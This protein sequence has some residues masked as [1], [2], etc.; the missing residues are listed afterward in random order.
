MSPRHKKSRKSMQFSFRVVR[1]D[2]GPIT[3]REVLAVLRYFRDRRAEPSGYRIEATAW[4]RGDSSG[5]PSSP[6][7]GRRAMLEK[8]WYILDAGGI[9]GLRLG[10]VK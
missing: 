1:Q 8:F 5:G 2:G 3:G 6:E 9:K 10:R 7:E 4:S